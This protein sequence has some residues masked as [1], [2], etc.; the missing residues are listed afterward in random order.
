[1]LDVP[2]RSTAA[3][4]FGPGSEDFFSKDEGH[5]SSMTDDQA[6]REVQEADDRRV[7]ALLAKDYNAVAALLS[8]KLVY[9]HASGKVDD[10]DSYLTQFLDGRVAFLA[11][12]RDQVTIDIVGETAICHGIARNDLDVEGR[13]ISAAT[14]FFSVW[15]REDGRWVMVAWSSA[16]LD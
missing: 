15:A 3:V 5:E 1:M 4:A 7:A 13:R 10:K 12:H 6:Q 9:H 14:R 2:P 8:D 16:K 11:A